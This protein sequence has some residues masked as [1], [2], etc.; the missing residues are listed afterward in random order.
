MTHSSICLVPFACTALVD[1]VV[2]TDNTFNTIRLLVLTAWITDAAR[3]T[4]STDADQVPNLRKGPGEVRYVRQGIKRCIY[5][6]VFDI[7]SNFDGRTDDLMT[8]YLR[9]VDL[10]PTGAHRMLRGELVPKR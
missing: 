1:T 9:I 4:L 6:D 8:N 3:V 7:L 10:A 2:G 5:F